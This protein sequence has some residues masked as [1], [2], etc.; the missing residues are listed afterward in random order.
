M[1]MVNRS[2]KRL[3][4]EQAALQPRSL[5]VAWLGTM[6]A[7]LLWYR[8]AVR[9]RDARIEQGREVAAPQV[10]CLPLLLEEVVLRVDVRH[11]ADAL[12]RVVQDA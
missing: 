4:A 6:P 11:L 12:D 8:A 7:R 5:S 9:P 10:R 3:G 1:H 2:F